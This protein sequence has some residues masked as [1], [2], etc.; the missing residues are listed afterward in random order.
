[1]KRED[2]WVLAA[3]VQKTTRTDIDKVLKD[4][5][6]RPQFIKTVVEKEVARRQR[7]AARK[8]K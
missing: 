1:M 6:T 7:A 4:G 3:R 8:A 5:E 2:S